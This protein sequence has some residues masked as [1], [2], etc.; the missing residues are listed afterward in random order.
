MRF[1]FKTLFTLSVLLC[2]PL[3]LLA[4]PDSTAGKRH[5]QEPE[6]ILWME[7]V[8]N[9]YPRWS[10]DG[11]KILFQSN[12]S[13]KW[14][15]YV[16]NRDGW[17]EGQIT[18]DSS[19]NNLPDW[20]PDNSMLAFVSDRGGNE[21]V[22]VM[23][24]DGRGLKNLSNHPGRDIHPYWA[25]DGKSLLFNSNRDR[26]DG[27][28][29]YRVN[30]DGSKLKRLTNS[31]DVKTCARFSPDGK[32]I[33]Y[34]SGGTNDDV[35]VMNANG[36]NPVNLTKSAAAE[37]WPAWSPDGK[38]IIYSCDE[39]GTFSLY[40]IHPDGSARRQITFPQPPYRDARAMISP[41]GSMLVFNRQTE[42]TI[43]IYTLN[44]PASNA[45]K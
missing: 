14:Q 10:K 4:Q 9:A 45:T 13:G 12:R 22:Y 27:F 21:D 25:P 3:S 30:V 15:I 26:A 29:I 2:L 43:G 44:L 18:R 17:H 24:M 33:V 8:Q 40:F 42:T 19:N 20:S 36:T 5:A 16:M 35:V 41:D 1:D 11:S 28:E 7:N 39:P 32:K 6:R 23:S 38:R 31:P 37:G 34:L